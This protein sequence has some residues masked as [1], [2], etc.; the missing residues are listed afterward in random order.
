VKKG[1]VAWLVVCTLAAV[2]GT[3]RAQKPGE[4]QLWLTNRDKSAVFEEQKPLLRFT[5]ASHK[6][7]SEMQEPT[8]DID[9]QKK[10]QSIDGFGFALTG[11]SAQHLLHMDTAARAALL[12]ELFAVDGKSIGISYLRISIGA[13][14]L[15]DHVYS[16]DDLAAG[17]S[18][19]ELAKFS[20][21]PDPRS[22]YRS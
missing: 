5:K 1:L 12:R 3:L 19:S 4:A 8:I 18:D 7:A 22:S 13:S 20:L 14:D 16:Y 11:G 15:N 6:L 2:P 21:G 17:E 9:D 10:F